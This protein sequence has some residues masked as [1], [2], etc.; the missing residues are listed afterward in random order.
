MLAALL[1]GACC[2]FAVAC[3]EEQEGL[4]DANRAGRLKDRLDRIDTLVATGRCAGVA[5]HLEALRAAI[6][7]LPRTT[8]DALR[9]RLREGAVT[10]E[11]QA[12][13]EC[14][15]RQQT[16]TQPETTETLPE[17]T[18]TLPETTETEPPPTTTTAPP[19]T[20]TPPPT[21]TEP[22]PPTTEPPP[23]TTTPPPPDSGGSEAP[24][25]QETP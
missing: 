8:D 16:D 14:L 25:G 23:P 19:T 15:E 18:E 24:P 21:T 3:G 6:E 10:L 9:T 22:P 17:T 2:A 11:R 1:A 4:L 20:T 5:D 7:N 12:I 13:D